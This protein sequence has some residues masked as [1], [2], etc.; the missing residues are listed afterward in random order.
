VSKKKRI[1][2]TQDYVE[3]LKYDLKRTKDELEKVK[4]DRETFRIEFLRL[5]R[6]N[7]RLLS[8]NEYYTT[9]TTV[10]RLSEIMNKVENW[11][12]S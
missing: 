12:W 1:T 5:L 11:W 9:E 2:L 3:G 10:N 6:D 7:V 4:K 8:K